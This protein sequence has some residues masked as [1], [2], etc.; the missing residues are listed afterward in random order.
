M[1]LTVLKLKYGA[2]E[3][4]LYASVMAYPSNEY[5]ENDREV[6]VQVA[7]FNLATEN[8][9]KLAKQISTIGKLPLE[10]DFELGTVVRDNKPMMILNKMLPTTQP[11][12]SNNG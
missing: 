7:K 1:K 5:V 4:N 6:G 2:V 8:G 3:S 9:N 12:K 10:L 11:V